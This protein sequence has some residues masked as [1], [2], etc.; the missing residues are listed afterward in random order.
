[1]QSKALA[2]ARELLGDS[3][4]GGAAAAPR[5][6]SLSDQDRA[7]RASSYSPIAEGPPTTSSSSRDANCTVPRAS[8]EGRGSIQAAASGSPKESTPPRRGGGA[9]AASTSRPGDRAGEGG[10][11]GGPGAAHP[12]WADSLFGEDGGG[13]CAK[14]RTTVSHSGICHDRRA[15][16]DG[17]TPLEAFPLNNFVLAE[18]YG[19]SSPI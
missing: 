8:L 4:D 5:T 6:A 12:S 10:G 9:P 19:M 1:M 13:V 2:T 15:V 11:G 18:P 3:S 14:A 16:R 7:Y 17:L